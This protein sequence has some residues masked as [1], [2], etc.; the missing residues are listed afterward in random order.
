MAAFFLAPNMA[1][2]GIFVLVP[3]VINFFYSATSGTAYFLQD[4]TYVGLEQYQRLLDCGS[5]LDTATCREDLFWKAVHNTGLFVVVQV[6]MMTIVSIATALILNREIVGRSFW[7]AVFFFPVLLSP[8]VTGLIWRWILQRQ[9]LLNLIVHDMGGEPYNWLTDRF[10]AFTAAVSVS[11]WAHMGFYTLILLAGLQAIPRDLYEAAEMDGTKPA[12]V[13]WRI[14]LPLLMPN[15]LVVI[16]LALIR[17]VQI[18]DEVYV[19]TGGGP[20]TSTLYL[21]QYIYEIGFA[22]LLR[23]PGLAS[24]AS[25]LMGL[26]LVVLTL[27]QL[28]VGRR[29]ERKGARE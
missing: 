12:R 10:W 3:L 15:L 25:I 8:V 4:R 13:F 23:N 22:S 11:V 21:T 5:Y 7:R 9:G 17:A 14:T 18:F 24:A 19:L 20:G 16:V 28:Q 6:A 1:I 2:F 27:L 29:G 26:V